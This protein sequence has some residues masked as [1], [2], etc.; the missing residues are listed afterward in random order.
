M[1]EA[2][3][4]DPDSSEPTSTERTGA[5]ADGVDADPATRR[6]GP[7]AWTGTGPIVPVLLAA[8]VLVAGGVLLGGRAR[9]HRS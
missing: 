8:A 4:T 9:R 7:L 2:P 1:A 6:A 3:V 5:A